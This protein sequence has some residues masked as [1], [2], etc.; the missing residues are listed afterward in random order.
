MIIVRQ[1]QGHAKCQTLPEVPFN[2]FDDD[3]GTRF[4]HPL[5]QFFSVTAWQELI[6]IKYLNQIAHWQ[7][8]YLYCK[9]L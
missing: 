7:L 4:P 8:C 6:F 5:L 3:N 1:T 9:D 2:Y